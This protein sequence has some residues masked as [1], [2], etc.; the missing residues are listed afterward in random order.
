VDDLLAFLRA[1]LDEDEAAAR[2]APPGPWRI[3]YGT[4]HAP[5]HPGYR[6]G[7]LLDARDMELVSDKYGEVGPQHEHFARHD[8]SRVLRDVEAKRRILD[9]YE[10]A[11]ELAREDSS[12]GAEMLSRSEGLWY[13]VHDLASVSSD[14]PDYR[15]EWGS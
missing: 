9:T 4:P 5:L 10:E 12:L 6:P 11:R 15:E 13:V 2:A 8:P 7:A 1:R 3:K 14:H